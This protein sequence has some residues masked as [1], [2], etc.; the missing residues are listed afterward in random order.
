MSLKIG[1][2][3]STGVVGSDLKKKIKKNISVFKGDITKKNDVYHWIKSNKFKSIYHLAAVV[4]IKEFNRGKK[5]GLKVN[6]T[7]TKHLVDA[8]IKF[9]SKNLWFFYSS[10]SHVYNLFNK[11]YKIKET[12]ACKPQNSYGHSKKLAEDYIIEKFS[13]FKY[14]YT[15]G[16]IFSLAHKNQKES[17]FTPSIIKRLIKSKKND[18]NEFFNVNHYRDFLTTK[19]IISAIIMLGKK[20]KLGIYNI[21]S[22]QKISLIDII[23]YFNKFLKKK[24]KINLNNKASYLIAN[25]SKLKKIGWKPK[26]NFFSELHNILRYKKIK[27]R[28]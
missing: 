9:Q 16:R 1:I 2:T 4:P 6:Y 28:Q 20:K 19:D 12:D 17:Y 5:K 26:Y 13:K 10:T 23:Y 15:I 18:F 21:G 24:I 8:I 22:G 25:N 3:G 14:N 27:I 11:N 7:G